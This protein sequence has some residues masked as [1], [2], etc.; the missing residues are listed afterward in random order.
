MKQREVSTAPPLGGLGR[1]R[2]GPRPSARGVHGGASGPR[3]AVRPVRGHGR[4]AAGVAA[5]A[6]VVAL[7]TGAQAAAAPPADG[8]HAGMTEAR[9]REL[10]ARPKGSISLG[11]TGSGRLLDAARL[12]DK[13]TGYAVFPGFRQRKTN[14]GTSELVSVVQRATRRVRERFP[15]SQLGVGNCGFEGGGK[16]PWSVSH[17][18]GR[19]CDLGMY[20]TDA[21]GR[22]VEM[23]DFV[24]YDDEGK[25]SGGRYRFD[26]ARN[27]ELM[28]A[29]VGDEVPVQYIFVAEWLK[30]RLLEEAK[31]Q[32]LPADTVMRLDEVLHQPS[33][34]NPH[35]NHFHVRIFCSVEDRLQGCRN[36]GPE[37]AWVDLGDAPWAERV[38]ALARVVE[39]V[40]ST[41][42][43][44]DAIKRIGELH[45]TPALP[46]LLAAL[47]DPRDDVR[48][49][50]LRAIR[51]LA[52]PEAVDGLLAAMAETPDAR[53]A[54]RIFDAVLATNDPSTVP[55]ALR[56]AA[57]PESL[58]H[59]DALKRG[60]PHLQ[61]TACRILGR[62]GKADSAPTLLDLLESSEAAVRTAAHEALLRVTN[63]KISGGGL[64]SSSARR[65]ARVVKAWRTFYEKEKDES[66]LQWLRVGF[67]ARGIR[68][69]GK[70]QSP[71]GVERLIAAIGN[72]DAVASDN[73][74]RALS[75]I[76]GHYV[77]PS[78][79]N[80]R[81][82]ERHWRSWWAD[83]GATVEFP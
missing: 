83:N 66:W 13:G 11:T 55:V 58:L 49:D 67:E 50:A 44:R 74:V 78:W 2:M 8:D 45:G 52:E 68:F 43:R 63:Q 79:R 64:S 9:A 51:A 6:I 48:S 1:E 16:I 23:V 29:F 35:A 62:F 14:F 3:R 32:D 80:K 40:P 21:R 65:R 41:R 34:S 59:A 10:L 24:T 7:S 18:A 75:E 77:D 4:I 76:T 36:W 56:A 33:D 22:P 12:A 81:N 19:D 31:R 25:A 54:G 71:A 20:A 72:R 5:L 82:N 38:A 61:A 28:V 60:G 30:A 53:W 15:G 42:I 47:A 73:A 39:E 26:L 46:T 57:S 70:M 17:Q 69:R 37:R 27:L